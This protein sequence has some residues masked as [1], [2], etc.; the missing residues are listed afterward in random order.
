MLY[1]REAHAGEYGFKDVEQPESFEQRRELAAKACDE[2]QIATT[3]V[4]DDMKDSVRQAYGRV[5]NSADIVD[6]GGRIVFKE[7]WAQPSAWREVLRGLLD[8]GRN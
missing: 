3:V 2:L 1:Q 4:I 5:P 7:P 6:K 8:D